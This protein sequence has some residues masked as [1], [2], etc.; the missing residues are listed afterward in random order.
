MHPIIETGNLSRSFGDIRAVDS[1]DLRVETGA[2][3]AFL[4]ANGAGKTT[5]IRMLLGLIR[6]DAGTVR[7]FGEPFRRASLARIGSLVETPSLYPHLTGRENLEVIRRLTGRTRA[8]I[9]CALATVKLTD[10]A[11]RPVSGYS[12]GM[13]QRLGLAIALL[14]NP[15]LLILDEPTNGLDPAGIRELRDL[16]TSLPRESGMTLFVSSHL[17]AEV[18]Q[19]ATH[20]SIIDRGRLLFQGTLAD[21]RT[22]MQPD[23]EIETDRPQEAASLLARAD[24]TVECYNGTG[25]TVRT[26][27]PASAA[28][29]NALLVSRGF[30]VHHLCLRAPSLEQIFLAVTR[31]E[32][33]NRL[34]ATF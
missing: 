15:R 13:R 20:V 10:A 23:L 34:C 24:Y 29:A 1:V 19:I 4:G 26:A 2:V 11:R 31:R 28:R 16:M 17:L 6:P 8:D 7:L 9:D 33:E 22:R 27:D 32:S 18:E 3:H 12:L 25:L 14:S 21:L 5:T 30:A